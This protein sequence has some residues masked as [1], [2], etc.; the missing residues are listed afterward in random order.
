MLNV[1][2]ERNHTFKKKNQCHIAP[3]LMHELITSSMSL[4]YTV[5]KWV[6]ECQRSLLRSYLPLLWCQDYFWH[7]MCIGSQ[8][9][10]LYGR[11]V[12]TKETGER[13]EGFPLIHFFHPGTR[14]LFFKNYYYYIIANFT[15]SCSAGN[16]TVWT[17]QRSTHC[18]CNVHYN[19]HFTLYIYIYI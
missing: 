12:G 11:G 4:N 5:R 17:A 1:K 16:G 19:F 3:W 15:S 18:N 6:Q 2:K 7:I 8:R 14:I 10:R 13:Q 9:K